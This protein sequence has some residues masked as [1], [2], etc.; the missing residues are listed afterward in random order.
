[1]PFANPVDPS[2]DPYHL[3]R[4]LQAQASQYTQ[5][6]QELKQGHK[7]SHWIW[8]IFPQLRGLGHSDTAKYYGLSGLAEAQAYWQHPILGARLLDCTRTFLAIRHKSARDILGQ[9][10]DL[11]LRSCMTLFA[12]VQIQESSPTA[13]FQTVLDRYFGSKPDFQTLKLL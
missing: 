7:T 3:D 9:P 4:F 6:L 10:D 1:M 5:A 8:Y 13:E 2:V 12:R 11:K